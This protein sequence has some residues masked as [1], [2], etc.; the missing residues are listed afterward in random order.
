MERAK[1]VTKVN[2]KG[3]GLTSEGVSLLNRIAAEILKESRVEG[4]R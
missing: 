2:K 4:G 1:L 3:R